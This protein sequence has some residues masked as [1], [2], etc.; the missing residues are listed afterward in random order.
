MKIAMAQ[1]NPT[2]GDLEGNV[3]KISHYIRESKKKEVDLVAFPELA[4]TGYPPQDLLYV[5]GFVEENKRLLEKIA[6]ESSGIT[7]AVGF[8]DYD[9]SRKGSDGTQVK[10]NSAAVIKDG[11]LMGV[12]HK[13]LLPTYDVFDEDR[14]FMPAI[15]HRV[16]DIENARIGIEICEDLWDEGYG[17]EVTKILADKGAN[18]ILNLSA[19]PFYAGKRFVRQRLL[20][21]K[22]KENSVSIFYVNCV[23]GQDELVFDGQS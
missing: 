9:P 4:V 2:V 5:N 20:Q 10:Y 3:E 6:K 22:A 15:E 21:K 11:E 8:V 18:L 17:V 12:Q 1:I 14:Y 19:S 13:T 7:A 16:F 23:G